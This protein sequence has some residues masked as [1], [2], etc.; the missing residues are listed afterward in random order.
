IKI[1]LAQHPFSFQKRSSNRYRLL[2]RIED[3]LYV[4]FVIRCKAMRDTRIISDRISGGSAFRYFRRCDLVS[5]NSDRYRW[6]V[7]NRLTGRLQI[8][9]IDGVVRKV[10]VFQSLCEGIYVDIGIIGR[11]WSNL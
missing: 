11:T 3:V 10:G 2:E 9:D 5:L 7:L 6:I 4:G 8:I 1:L